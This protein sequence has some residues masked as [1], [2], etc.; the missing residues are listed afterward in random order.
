MAAWRPR[1]AGL[2]A[3][4]AILAACKQPQLRAVL[5]RLPGLDRVGC[6][7]SVLDGEL[8]GIFDLVTDPLHRRR[9]YGAAL[10]RELLGWGL[11]RGV[12]RAY[13][14]VVKSNVAAAALYR[15]LGFTDAYQ[16]WYRI[17]PERA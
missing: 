1:T 4:R 7:L 9:G 8:L 10:M 11:D 13:L 12:R 14:Q 16:Y 17:R 3:L 2:P 15:K 5:E 6:G